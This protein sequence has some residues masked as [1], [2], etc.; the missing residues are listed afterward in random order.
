MADMIATPANMR[1]LAEGPVQVRGATLIAYSP[2]TSYQCSATAGDYWNLA[3]DE[4]L[5][6]QNGDPMFLAYVYEGIAIVEDPP[7]QPDEDPY[8]KA[9]TALQGKSDD[10]V[11]DA[12]LRA[13]GTQILRVLHERFSYDGEGRGG[14][15]SAEAIERACDGWD[16]FQR[17]VAGDE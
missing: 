9:I 3:D 2:R 13:A 11:L 4:P 14:D 1:K 6:D 7:A 8:A 5:R 10:G 17:T 15:A 16:A 12:E